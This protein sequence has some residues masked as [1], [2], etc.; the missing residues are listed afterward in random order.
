MRTQGRLR[1]IAMGLV[2]TVLVACNGS[3]GDNGIVPPPGPG[4]GLVST[5]PEVLVL[6]GQQTCDAFKS[7][8]SD[9]IA[10][11]ILNVGVVSCPSCAV[12]IGGGTELAAAAATDAQSFDAFT[13]TNSQEAGVDEADH[14]D[15]NAD[16]YFFLIDGRHLVVAD[17]LP[18]DGLSE[19]ASLELKQSGYVEGLLLD[20]DNDRLVVVASDFSFFDPLPLSILPP[21]RSATELLFIDVADPANPVIDRRLSIEGF[22]LAVRRIGD[23]IHAVAHTTP[24]IPVSI[25]DNARLLELRQS[26]ANAIAS[27]DEAAQTTLE[28]EIRDLVDTLVAITDA[29]DYL[30][31]ITL[32]V[33]AQDTAIG[34]P[35]CA[36]V[37]VPDVT[38]PLALTSVTSIDSDGTD[39]SSLK[40]ANNSWNVYASEQNIYLTQTSGG[41][42][43]AD[44]QRQQTAIHKIAV[45]NGAPRSIA[46]GLV[47]GW[48]GSPFQFGEHAGFLRVVTSRSEFDPAANVFLRDNNLY[49]LADD[50]V[51]SLDV[52][53]SELGFGAME[54]IF[55]TRLVGDRGF[56]VTFRQI[57]PLFT[58]DL[59]DP[60]NPTLVGELEIPGVS[61][62]IHPIGDTHLL[63]IGYDG[64]ETR[65]NGQFAVSLFN[66]ER[67]DE[68][69]LVDRLVPQFDAHGFAWTPAVWD[70][71][72]FNFFPDAGTLTVPVQYYASSW[73]EHFSGFIAFSVDALTGILELGRLDHSDLARQTHCI[74]P[75]ALAPNLCDS[76]IYLEAAN[77]RR[78][79]SAL[80]G[81]RAFIYTLSNL[82]MKVSPA[83]DFAN[84]VATLPLPY[85]NEYPWLVQ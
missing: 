71:L 41:W 83:V 51:G 2:S 15:V 10:D 14:V 12:R 4:L 27:S 1:H 85:R 17:G 65:L 26:L 80:V 62:Y 69:W 29:G 77:P 13:G 61:T 64:N 59:S 70:H 36:D 47:N 50:G 11:L 60:R 75:N 38:M 63:T 22:K 76:G 48:A 33:G 30:P 39:V 6:K 43:F 21:S 53:G 73:D 28:G 19:I 54:T 18:P 8:V 49:V 52:V 78:A 35:I 84:P 3:G 79:V 82:G 44:R 45:G 57:D 81:D 68:P 34:S 23:R 55:S 42:W 67:L 58:F 24:A 74:G 31:D 37:A 7:Y 40:V 20:A 9:S 46:T 32:H 5:P 56:V 66:V 25:Y 72:A 16:G